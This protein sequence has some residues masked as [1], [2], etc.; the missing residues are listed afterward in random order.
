MVMETY[1]ERLQREEKMTNYDMDAMRR[2]QEFAE[3]LVEHEKKT[4][5][6]TRILGKDEE[7]WTAIDVEIPDEDFIKI[8]HAPH[9]RDITINKM[10]NLIL[11]D[12]IKNAEYRFEHGKQFLTENN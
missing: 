8:A 1:A 2:K 12:G 7:A 5:H 3:G 4:V 9:T 11:K 6:D 10:V